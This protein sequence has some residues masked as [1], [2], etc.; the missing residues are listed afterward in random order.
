M[1][2]HEKYMHVAVLHIEWERGWEGAFR[3]VG[4]ERLEERAGESEGQAAC[5]E[6]QGQGGVG[7]K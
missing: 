6:C 4:W 5:E 7:C 3:R 1:Q 2:Q